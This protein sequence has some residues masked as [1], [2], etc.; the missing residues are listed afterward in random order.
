MK[1]EKLISF[2]KAVFFAVLLFLCFPITFP[3]TYVGAEGTEPEMLYPDDNNQRVMTSTEVGSMT[4][5][6]TLAGKDYKKVTF[7]T[8]DKSTEYDTKMIVLDITRSGVVDFLCYV[9]ESVNYCVGV[10]NDEACTDKVA[11]V[12]GKS[13]T[14]GDLLNDEL[15]FYAQ[16]G[17]YY[18]KVGFANKSEKTNGILFDCRMA[19][20]VFPT[21]NIKITYDKRLVTVD[22]SVINDSA[23]A[24][25]YYDQKMSFNNFKTGKASGNMTMEGV[26]Y[27]HEFPDYGDY[28]LGF[29]IS[30]TKAGNTYRTSNLVPIQ[31]H[32][33]LA[34]TK[35]PVVKGVKNKKIYTAARKIYCL[36]DAEVKSATLNG[37]AFESGSSVSTPGDYELVVED[38]KGNKKEVHFTIVDIRKPTVKG[39]KNGKT[40]SAP[41]IITFSDKYGIQGAT[42]NGTAIESGKKVKKAGSYEL[43]VTDMNQNIRKVKFWIK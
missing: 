43:V 4:G 33:P 16:G 1:E 18:A 29:Q 38:Y 27:T 15:K 2:A 19:L 20:S 3:A 30:G 25:Y 17:R 39:V 41:V 37:T 31:I 32:I 35:A 11:Y 13:S 7:S 24:M 26:L 14:T 8:P 21:D 9:P 42:L 5:L 23:N 36:D 10:Y 34:D 6:V 28:T 12:E 22:S 40:Y